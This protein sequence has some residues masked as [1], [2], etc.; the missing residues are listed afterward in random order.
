MFGWSPRHGA[1]RMAGRRQNRPRSL[2]GQ[3]SQYAATADP[4][5]RLTHSTKCQNFN[6]FTFSFFATCNVVPSNTVLSDRSVRNPMCLQRGEI[7]FSTAAMS[8]LPLL[9]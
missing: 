3:D 6:G 7:T 4:F 2:T 8:L 5:L 9:K 1:G